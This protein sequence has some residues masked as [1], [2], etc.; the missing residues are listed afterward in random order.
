LRLYV[1]ASGL[2][3]GNIKSGI[4]ADNTSTASANVTF[5]VTDLTGVPVSGIPPVTMTLN[6]GEQ[7]AKFLSDIFPFLP[8]PF[9]G[10][11]RITTTSS[12]I[13]VV[14]LRTR[15]NERGDFLITTTP[16]ANESSSPA[17]MPMYFPQVADGGGYTTQ[18]IL[19]SGTAGQI[20]SGI[21]QLA[22]PDGSP[23]GITLN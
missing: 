4:A 6:G 12:G 3:A 23:F 10:V 19:F 18:F 8:S 13:S 20:S 16:P 11:L 14:G 17:N 15:I 1:E 2:T 21:L 7:T 9:K 5:D 22:N